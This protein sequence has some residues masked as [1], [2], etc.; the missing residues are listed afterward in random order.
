MQ[1]MKLMYEQNNR[2]EAKLDTLEAQNAGL[3]RRLEEKEAEE[4]NK[5]Q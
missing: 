4:H 1:L 3:K 5:R 2:L